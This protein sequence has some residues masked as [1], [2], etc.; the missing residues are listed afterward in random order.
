MS[1]IDKAKDNLKTVKEKFKELGGFELFYDYNNKELKPIVVANSEDEIEQKMEKKLKKYFEKYK[2]AKLVRVTIL[3]NKKSIGKTKDEL[4]TAGGAF[5]IVAMVYGITDDLELTRADE[6]R[7][8][9]FW[10]DD[11]ELATRGF[12]VKDLKLVIKAVYKRMIDMSPFAIYQISE[13]DKLFPNK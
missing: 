10:Y 5:A 3:A 12:S 1:I 8:Q 7:Q 2:N 11:I 13:L 6:H 4:L 9:A